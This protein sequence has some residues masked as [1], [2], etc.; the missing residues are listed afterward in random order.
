MSS[1]GASS[2]PRVGLRSV[3]ERDTRSRRSRC[4]VGTRSE[5]LPIRTQMVKVTDELDSL[6]TIR[7]HRD[8]LS[9]GVSRY[10]Y[11]VLLK[12]TDDTIFFLLGLKVSFFTG[13]K[14]FHSC[15]LCVVT[16]FLTLPSQ[17]RGPERRRT[18]STIITS[19]GSR[20]RNV[21]L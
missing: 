10:L 13:T 20:K 21:F 2:L 5:S 15:I 3:R 18:L 17:V 16:V 7:R 19:K 8:P 4:G 9:V 6:F 12:G 1:E 11:W 14:R